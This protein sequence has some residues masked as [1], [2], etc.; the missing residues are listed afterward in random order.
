MVFVDDEAVVTEG[1]AQD[2][3]VEVLL[4]KLADAK[5]WPA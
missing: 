1:V 4:V 5:E 3:F 2:Q